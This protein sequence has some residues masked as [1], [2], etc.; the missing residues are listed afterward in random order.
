MLWYLHLAAVAGVV[1]TVYTDHA[2]ATMVEDAERGGYFTEATLH[3]AVTIAAGSDAT[4][5]VALHRDAHKKCYVA[6]SLN[7]PVLCEPVIHM[8]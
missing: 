4:L 3:P 8:I 1:V 2:T 6:N 5:A 7:F